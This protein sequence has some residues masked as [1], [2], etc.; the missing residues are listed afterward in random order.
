MASL[1]KWHFRAV[2]KYSTV[3]HWRS[4]LARSLCGSWASASCI[5]SG[6][7]MQKC[8]DKLIGLLVTRNATQPQKETFWA[9][10][11]W[12]VCRRFKVDVEVE[13]DFQQRHQF[14]MDMEHVL[15][16]KVGAGAPM[17]FPRNYRDL[18]SQGCRRTNR[19]T[20]HLSPNVFS[21]SQNA[22]ATQ[23]SLLIRCERTLGLE[24]EESWTCRQSFVDIFVKF[25]PVFVWMY[26]QAARPQYCLTQ[27]A[28]S[29]QSLTIWRFTLC[30]VFNG[31]GL[32]AD[33]QW[34]IDW[35]IDWLIDNW[36]IDRSIDAWSDLNLKTLVRVGSVRGQRRPSWWTVS[37]RV[38]TSAL[39]N[40]LMVIVCVWN[41]IEFLRHAG[42]VAVRFICRASIANPRVFYTQHRM[43]WRHRIYGYDTTAILWV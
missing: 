5:H 15:L 8:R 12:S 34:S 25:T 21:W 35:L 16:S 33:N 14:I 40:W 28:S 27:T 24:L 4:V 13:F 3:F 10:S 38:T 32:S 23:R 17:T 36:L 22:L 30:T 41:D 39:V 20:L 42:A 18:E 9:A 11:Q 37:M 31:C 43:K 1:F 6:V 19:P 7:L 26:W 2:L 29:P